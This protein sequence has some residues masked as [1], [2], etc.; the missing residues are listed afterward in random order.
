M[1][2]IKAH[3]RRVPLVGDIALLGQ[4]LITGRWKTD[5]GFWIRTLLRRRKAQI[6]VIGANDGQT[7][8]PIAQLIHEKKC[9]HVLFVEPV[10]YLFERLKKNYSGSSRFTFVNVAIASESESKTFYWVDEKAKDDFPSISRFYD[11]LG[12][13]NRDHILHHLDGVLE[14]YIITGEVQSIP[15]NDLLKRSGLTMIDLLQ[16]D[17]EGYDY[18]VLSGLDLSTYQPTLI[19]F[20]HRH[21]SAED[22]QR[23]IR[24]LS[25]NYN[26]IYQFKKDILAVHRTVAPL[27][28]L[29]LRF[30][31]SKR[32]N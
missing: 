32:V 5:P 25:T 31:E 10:P 29:M 19:L 15:L 11:Q 27:G 12:S 20:E 28:K 1:Q 9:W 26:T 18:I 6:V 14:P 7:G 21:L 22:K 17:T 16:I 23:A 2:S 24:F 8:D 3:I 13:F 4:A 30:L